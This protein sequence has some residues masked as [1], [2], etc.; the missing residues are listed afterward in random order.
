MSRSDEVYVNHY[1]FDG[2]R[3]VDIRL[4]QVR[5][6]KTRKPQRCVS[7][8]LQQQHDIPVGTSVRFEKALVEGHWRSYYLCKKC[9]DEWFELI[10]E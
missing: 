5:M 2:D 1:P 8:D 4:Q 10:G 3:D 9:M 6:V 7:N